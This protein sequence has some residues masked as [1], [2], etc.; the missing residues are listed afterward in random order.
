MEEG[1]QE[2]GGSQVV[3]AAGDGEDDGDQTR[4]VGATVQNEE[5]EDG[6]EVELL[7]EPLFLFES[8]NLPRVKAQ[9]AVK[10]FIPSS[11]CRR[12]RKEHRRERGLR[13]V[14]FHDIRGQAHDYTPCLPVS[15]HSLV[16][17][18]FGF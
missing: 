9:P 5:N 6:D 4:G 16:Q 13:S 14:T 1:W 11:N 8:L 18:F 10:S 12:P 2:E 17:T 7:A 3:D 15:S